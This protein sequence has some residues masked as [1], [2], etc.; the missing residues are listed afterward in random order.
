MLGKKIKKLKYVHMRI[1]SCDVKA[2]CF[3]GLMV[4]G[5]WV[6]ETVETEFVSLFFLFQRT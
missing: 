5:S 6:E 2:S 3:I 1:F 4:V